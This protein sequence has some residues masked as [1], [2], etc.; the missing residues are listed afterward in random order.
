[1]NSLDLHL[2]YGIVEDILK[3]FLLNEIRKFGFRSV[4][5]GLSGGIDSA[6]VCELAS[7][8]L[9]SDQV[10]ALMMPYRSSSTDSI[11]HAQL[12]V[13]KLGIRAETCSITAAVDAFFEG[14]PEEDRLRRGNI[15]A[16][17]RMVYLYDVSARQN[18]LVVGTSNKTELLLGYGTLFGD[19]ASAVNP[20]GDLYK[21]QIRGLARHLGIP[22]QLITKTPS[23]DLWEGQSDEADLG[24][25]YDEVDHLLFM[26]LEKRMDKAAIIE[27]GVSEIFYDRVRKMVVRN[28]YKR[29]MPVIAKI[30]SR[31]PGI[32]FR[33]ARD[34]QEVK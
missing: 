24:F 33:Y 20:V 4:V 25:S 7:R 12:L 15:M 28:Q 6:V 14:V 27:Q 5:L 22:E 34:W 13:E 30:S 21:T 17:T 9:G 1:M 18:S 23:A 16:R 26:M 3:T 32:D 8:A 31:T 19:M 2:D 10:L 29:M 11:V